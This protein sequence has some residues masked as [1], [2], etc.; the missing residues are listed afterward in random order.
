MIS[1]VSKHFGKLP[2]VMSIITIKIIPIRG[3]LLSFN[4]Y[5]NLCP[6]Y[7]FFY[8]MLVEYDVL[9]RDHQDANV[10]YFFNLL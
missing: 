7:R 4:Y 8:Q 2:N 1:M 9:A 10:S 5:Y 6:S 3:M